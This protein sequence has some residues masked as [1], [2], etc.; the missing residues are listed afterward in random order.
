MVV[1]GENLRREFPAPTRERLVAE[2]IKSVGTARKHGRAG[3]LHSIDWL[4]TS[5][6]ILYWLKEGELASKSRAA[7]WAYANAAGD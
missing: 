4:L 7:D 5:A 2:G 6:R 3:G 1:H